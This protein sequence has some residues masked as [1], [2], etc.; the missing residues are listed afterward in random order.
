[1]TDVKCQQLLWNLIELFDGKPALPASILVGEMMQT[2]RCDDVLRPD[3]AMKLRTLREDYAGAVG[4]AEV[5]ARIDAGDA[6]A[7]DERRCLRAVAHYRSH[8]NNRL[9]EGL[10]LWRKVQY[11]T[12][13]KAERNLAALGIAGLGLGGGRAMYRIGRASTEYVRSRK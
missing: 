2:R 8:T 7:Q 12:L 13:Y 11:Q 1:M 3:I 6:T 5:M 4:P 10:D 9:F